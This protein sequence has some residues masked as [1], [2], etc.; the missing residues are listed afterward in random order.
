MSSICENKTRKNIFIST[1]YL[2]PWMKW[3]L[4]RVCEPINIGIGT[5]QWPFKCD[6]GVPGLRKDEGWQE[7]SHFHIWTHS[8]PPNTSYAMWTH[9]LVL[10]FHSSV[11]QKLVESHPHV[12]T[13]FYCM[14]KDIVEE[15]FILLQFKVHQKIL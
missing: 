2:L 5:F 13:Y 15:I 7:H 1:F 10:I 14:W 3:N 9:H 6:E 4:T 12:P 8:L 11:K